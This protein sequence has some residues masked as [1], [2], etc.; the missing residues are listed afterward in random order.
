MSITSANR[1]MRRSLKVILVQ[2]S[3]GLLTVFCVNESNAEVDLSELVKRIQPSVATIIAYDEKGEVL[4]QGSGFFINEEG[5]L[6]TNFHVLSGAFTAAAKTQNG[7]TYD[8]ITI[9][10]E[11]RELDL[12]RLTADIPKS[13]VSPLKLTEAKPRVAER[14][15]VIGSPLGLEQTV[16]EGIVSAI[17]EIPS[18]GEIIQITAPISSGSSG[19]PVVN[20]RGVV[21]GVVSSQLTGGQNLNFAVPAHQIARLQIVSG[22]TIQEWTRRKNR[23]KVGPDYDLFIKGQS[24]FSLRK[25]E[26]AARL[27]EKA[28]E[29]N[30][31]AGTLLLLG[32]CYYQT[33]RNEDALQAF[34]QL[35]RIDPDFAEAYY[36]LGIAYGRL[37]LIEESIAAYERAIKIN[38]NHSGAFYRLGLTLSAVGREKEALWTY[39]Q[40]LRLD[41]DCTEAYLGLGRLYGKLKRS[42]E[43]LQAFEHAVKL[44]PESVEGHFWIGMHYVFKDQELAMHHYNILKKLDTARANELLKFIDM[45]LKFKNREKK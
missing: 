27:L 12:I 25:Y 31:N 16:S 13:A 20:A 37:F 45:S 33:D 9:V 15:V 29:L 36:H 42:E 7:K 1:N 39:K 8:I 24:L 2:F 5:D 23:G 43:A 38:P 3:L 28:S 40:A 26:E 35:I 6:I 21:I 17:R 22:E 32:I 18:V 41:P 34:K 10:G 14:V 11:S 4:K 30:P 19:S 44:D